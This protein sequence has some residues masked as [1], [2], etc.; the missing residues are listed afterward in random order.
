MEKRL[1]WGMAGEENIQ[2][3][4]SCLVVFINTG[5]TGKG[6]RGTAHTSY[7]CPTMPEFENGCEKGMF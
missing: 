3:R 6:A 5:L 4:N 1:I 7:G 2:V